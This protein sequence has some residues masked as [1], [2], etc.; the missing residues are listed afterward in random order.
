MW[1]PSRRALGVQEAQGPGPALQNAPFVNIVAVDGG[2]DR[3]VRGLARANSL[4]WR[5]WVLQLWVCCPVL[6][7]GIGVG[8]WLNL[9]ATAGHIRS[10]VLPGGLEI[11]ALTAS[12]FAPPSPGPSSGAPLAKL[13]AITAAGSK[14]SATRN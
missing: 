9:N 1:P 12:K 13:A 8:W 10:F 5:W 3:R 7:L 6:L 14:I 2:K 11:R 4:D